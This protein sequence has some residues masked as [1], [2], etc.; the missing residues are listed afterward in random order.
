MLAGPRLAP[1]NNTPIA[2]VPRK[3]PE[4]SLHSSNK[5]RASCQMEQHRPRV[6][7]PRIRKSDLERGRYEHLI[8]S[9]ASNERTKA[10]YQVPWPLENVYVQD[11]RISEIVF[12]KDQVGISALFLP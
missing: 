8:M 3:A 12:R 10:Y 5:I 6:S 7:N 11:F 9:A 2:L 1:G 4:N